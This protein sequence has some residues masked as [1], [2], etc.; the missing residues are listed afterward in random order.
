VLVSVEEIP[1]LDPEAPDL[2]GQPEVD[3]VDVGVGHGD[4]SGGELE[5]QRL[6]LVEVTH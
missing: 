4:V 1:G 6:H 5:A 3:H 2:H